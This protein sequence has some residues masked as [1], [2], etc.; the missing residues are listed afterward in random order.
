MLTRGSAPEVG[1]GQENGGFLE[2]GLIQF[3]V[4][5]ERAFRMKSPVV[6]KE[7]AETR[8]FDPFQKLFGG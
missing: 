1:A 8:S 2:T 6:E 5:I 4:G 7:L 3:K